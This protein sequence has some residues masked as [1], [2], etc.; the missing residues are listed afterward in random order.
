MNLYYSR[1]SHSY[2]GKKKNLKTLQIF[3]CI[4]RY[5]FFVD[6]VFQQ[7][8]TAI[9]KVLNAVHQ[10][11]IVLL[12]RH[13]SIEIPTLITQYFSWTFSAN[14]NDEI[15]IVLFWRTFFGRTFHIAIK[16]APQEN[17]SWL[18]AYHLRDLPTSD[19]WSLIPCVLTRHFCSS[20]N[21]SSSKNCLYD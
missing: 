17:L 10:N 13:T 9:L 16:F 19:F 1:K 7:R 14:Y 4:E 5:I 12:E 2:K 21:P 8:C 3:F 18:M 15:L 6:K 20:S 11:T